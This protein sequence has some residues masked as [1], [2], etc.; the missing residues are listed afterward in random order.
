MRWGCDRTNAIGNDMSIARRCGKLKTVA[1][2]VGFAYRCLRVN[3]DG[4]YGHDVERRVRM[5]SGRVEEDRK[6]HEPRTDDQR[7]TAPLLRCNSC[8]EWLTLT[9][10]EG[11]IAGGA[12]ATCPC[13]H[14]ITVSDEMVARILASIA[15]T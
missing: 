1:G 7:S 11:V 12:W 6:V 4:A 13:G 3:A 8:G 2:V 10:P 14:V 15:A 5:P 9:P